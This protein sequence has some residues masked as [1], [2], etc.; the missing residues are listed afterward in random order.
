[1]AQAGRYGRG[2]VAAVS[3]AVDVLAVMRAASSNARLGV[4]LHLTADAIDAAR[5]NVAELIEACAPV[6]RHDPAFD[7]GPESHLRAALARVQ[8]GAA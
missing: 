5:D 7:T 8:G 4:D 6:L 3:G 1:M 2:V